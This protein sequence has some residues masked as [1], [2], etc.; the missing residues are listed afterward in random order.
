M[1]LKS[2]LK[3][4]NKKQPIALYATDNT[5]ITEAG[6]AIDSSVIKEVYSHYLDKKV[7]YIGKS[8]IWESDNPE[9]I[10]VTVRV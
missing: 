7:I 9:I 10:Q 4:V 2:F 5:G 6:V 8:P 1:K 3:V